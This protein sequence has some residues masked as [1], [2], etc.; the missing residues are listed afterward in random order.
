MRHYLLL[1][2]NALS[3]VHSTFLTISDIPAFNS[4]MT[5]MMFCTITSFNMKSGQLEWDARACIKYYPLEHEPKLEINAY[6]DVIEH[7][8]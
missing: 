4:L 1:C 3:L 5:Q 7:L 8:Y 6:V 2:R